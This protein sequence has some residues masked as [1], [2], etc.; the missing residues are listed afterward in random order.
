MKKPRVIAVELTE[1][2]EYA[3]NPGVKVTKKDYFL[4]SSLDS[5]LSDTNG[6]EAWGFSRYEGYRVLPLKEVEN[7]KLEYYYAGLRAVKRGCPSFRLGRPRPNP[8]EVG[9]M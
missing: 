1:E 3:D 8:C 5:V 6:G 4:G 2:I 9:R 7:M